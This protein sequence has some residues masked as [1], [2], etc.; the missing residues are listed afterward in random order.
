MGLDQYLFRELPPTDD[1]EVSDREEVA[2]WRKCNQVHA[3][4]EAHVAKGEL[5]N[6][7][8]YAVDFEQLAGL[9]GTCKQ[10][11]ADHSLAESLLPTQSGFFYGSTDYDEY[12]FG[13]LES[14]VEQLEPL[15]ADQAAASGRYHYWAW[16]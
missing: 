1:P 14:T 7:E 3:W 5:E 4:F 12:Y 11:L 6:C 8:R 10:V 13:D 16:W 9:V 2:Y 15:L